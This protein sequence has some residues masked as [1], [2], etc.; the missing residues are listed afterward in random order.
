[1]RWSS[2]P[3]KASRRRRRCASRVSANASA[4]PSSMAP[5]TVTSPAHPLVTAT[6]RIPLCASRPATTFV[7]CRIASRSTRSS[8]IRTPSGRTTGN[9]DMTR[10]GGVS[11]PAPGTSVASL[12][13]A[14]RELRTLA[15][16][17]EAG[18]LAL[19][20]AG[21]TCE[22]T[23]F[24]DLSAQA[25]IGL[26]QRSG[27]AVLEGAGLSGLAAAVELGHHVIATLGA[28]L[29]HRST[30]R[31]DQGRPVEVLVQRL[32]VGRDDSGA[33]GDAYPRDR[34]L[35]LTG[36]AVDYCSHFNSSGACALCG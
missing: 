5:A 25:R 14:L 18:F 24:L 2:T 6:S 26:H 23:G 13:L 32:A 30:G 31:G 4:P 8:A 9:G 36:S 35:A 27:D 21:V 22:V 12:G 15:G 17:L 33:R 10:G 19:H 16:F 3:G 7:L 11:S 1:M 20:H 28:T 29:D 34:G